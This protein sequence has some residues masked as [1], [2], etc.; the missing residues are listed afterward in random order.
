[1]LQ[2]QVFGSSGGKIQSAVEQD[3]MLDFDPVSAVRAIIFHLVDE[4]LAKSVAPETVRRTTDRLTAKCFHC[5]IQKS[6]WSGMTNPQRLNWLLSESLTLPVM[7]EN[8]C[9]ML[10]ARR[11]R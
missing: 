4:K 7:A 8:D 5:H 11:S 6:R 10:R 1:M 3:V 2:Q 9:A